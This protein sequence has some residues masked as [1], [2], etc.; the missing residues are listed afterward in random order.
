MAWCLRAIEHT[1][2]RWGCKHGLNAYDRHDELPEA[3]D[4]L[5]RIAATMAPAELYI[6]RLDGSVENLGPAY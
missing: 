5:R 4:H 2:G 6:H 1:D 3:L